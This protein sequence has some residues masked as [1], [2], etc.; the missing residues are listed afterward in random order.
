MALA[1]LW[2]VVSCAERVTREEQEKR[3]PYSSASMR[4]SSTP[5][6]EVILA[7]ALPRESLVE[8]VNQSLL[9]LSRVK[10]TQPFA[11][12]SLSYSAKE[13]KASMELFLRLLEE[14]PDLPSLALALEKDFL[15]FA[16]SANKNKAVL[17]T[18]YYEPIY[19]G[20]RVKSKDFAVPV[21]QKPKD[22]KV[23]E[24]GKF[25]PTLK[26]HTIVYRISGDKA[27]PYF[28]RKEIVDQGVLDSQELEFAWMKDPLDLFFLQV[29]GSGILVTPEGERIKLSYDGANGQP[30]A[31]I[32][33]LL[34]DE[35]KMKLEEVSMGSI[36]L[37][38]EQNPGLKKR[39]LNHNPSYVFFKLN[40][41]AGGPRG[42]IN[43]PLTPARS[44]AVD[45][46][47][48]PKGALAYLSTEVPH[49]D[50]EWKKRGDR[51]LNGF[52]LM[53]DT[54]GAIRGPGRVDLFWGNGELAENS[55]G[56]MR[57]QGMIY[58]LIAKKEALANQNPI[59]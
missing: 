23:L 8:A 31:S 2:L 27:V 25:R 54:G 46:S 34:V 26:D 47:Q 18:G 35:G 58:V 51:P 15:L 43:V 52:V 53:Q 1:A 17:F 13:V 42:N 48:W 11:Y 28:S 5:L 37:Y 20:S 12:G 50:A 9:Y 10:E 4:L 21:L 29:Q 56:V 30:Y 36:R 57:S 55:A 45:P 38:L 7:D 6:H 24:L 33:K 49:F 40:E 22:L 59:P 16:S 41:D 3:H 39:I 14:H 32:G 19:P 44:V